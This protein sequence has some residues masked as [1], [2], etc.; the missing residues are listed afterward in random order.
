MNTKEFIEKIKDLVR[1]FESGNGS[2]VE[3]LDYKAEVKTTYEGH[4]IKLAG[5]VDMKIIG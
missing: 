2:I 5:D 3:S 1:E 4:K